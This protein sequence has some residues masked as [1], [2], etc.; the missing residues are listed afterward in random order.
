MHAAQ[1][2]ALAARKEQI[3]PVVPMEMELNTDVRARERGKYDEARRERELEIEQQMDERR[4]QR[5]LEE[6]KE[7]RELRRRAVPKANEVPEW[8]ANA[9]KRTGKPK[10]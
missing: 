7:I 4:R 10:T 5:E 3:M 2:S 6:E 8:Y 1:E 9:P